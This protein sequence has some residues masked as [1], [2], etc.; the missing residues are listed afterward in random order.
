MFEFDDFISSKNCEF[1]G[2]NW[3]VGEPHENDCP[4][5]FIAPENLE[6]ALIQQY[7]MEAM[8]SAVNPEIAMSLGA[9]L[10]LASEAIIEA[11]KTWAQKSLS[12]KFK[13][14][15]NRYTDVTGFAEALTQAGVFLTADDVVNFLQDPGEYDELFAVWLEHGQPHQ[16][17]DLDAW[18]IFIN[19][20]HSQGWTT[21]EN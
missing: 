11:Q 14:V 8:A 4:T 18:Q 2:I 21:E 10:L 1:C 20:I 9:Q 16:K 13:E 7:E 5:N 17:D 19:A 3:E 6:A 12:M 15:L